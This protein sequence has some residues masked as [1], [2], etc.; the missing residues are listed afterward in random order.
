MD[1]KKSSTR[2]NILFLDVAWLGSSKSGSSSSN[3][4]W[5]IQGESDCSFHIKIF[6]TTT[7]SSSSTFTSLYSR[8]IP[9]LVLI[10][11]RGQCRSPYRTA[12]TALDEIFLRSNLSAL[13]LSGATTSTVAHKCS[14]FSYLQFKRLFSALACACTNFWKLDWTEQIVGLIAPPEKHEVIKIILTR[15]IQIARAL[16]GVSPELLGFSVGHV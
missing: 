16:V 2:S 1:W 5:L 6:F 10:L 4:S 9:R 7:F 3:F 13:T 15:Q 14:I 11:R 12:S 8:L